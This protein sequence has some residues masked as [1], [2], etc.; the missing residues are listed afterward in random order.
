MKPEIQIASSALFWIAVSAMAFLFSVI[1]MPL[2]IKLN[3]KLDCFDVPNDRKIHKQKTATLGGIGIIISLLLTYTF[4]GKYNLSGYF[5]ISLLLLTS[6]GIFDD[7]YGLSWNKKLLLQFIAATVFVSTGFNYTILFDNTIFSFIPVFMQPALIAIFIVLYINA[8]NLIDGMDGLAGGL[9]LINFL[10]FGTMNF[11]FGNYS[12]AWLCLVL[13]GALFGFLVYNAHPAKIF[14]GDTGSMSIG[15]LLV[16]VSF[17]TFQYHYHIPEL[18]LTSKQ[19][20]LWVI[21]GIL[22]LPFADASRVFIVRLLNG[23]LPYL[24]AKDHIHHILNRNGLSHRDT[25]L[26]LYGIN[27]L[28]VLTGVIIYLNKPISLI[29]SV[30]L[31]KM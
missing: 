7:I 1:L 31:L 22:F 17:Y 28:F 13:S 27:L 26:L 2:I 10:V 14:M 11:Y 29:V 8:F 12:M 5:W 16:M 19:M 18:S 20:F 3:K 25:V 6:A 30:L 9:A 23:K 4:L 21:I 24:P 15:F